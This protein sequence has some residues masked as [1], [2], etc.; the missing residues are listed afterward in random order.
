MKKS[1]IL[2]PALIAPFIGMAQESVEPKLVPNVYALHMS[3]NGK[4]IGSMAGDASIYNVETGENVY[5]NECAFGLG[6]AIANNGLGVGDSHDV[7]AV[8]L[9]GK[10]LN[11]QT[12]GGDNYW[13]CDI[14]AVTP[15][16]TRICGVIN[17]D[18][19]SQTLYIPFVASIDS[20]GN[21]GEPTMLPYPENDLFGAAPQFVTAVWISEDGKTVAGQVLDWRGQYSYPIYYV[22]GAD[23]KWSYE[24]PSAPLFNPT[25]IELPPNP[26]QD[27]PYYPE[28]EDFMS[29]TARE[30]YLAALQEFYDGLKPEAPYVDEYMDEEQYIEYA[31]AV[32]TYNQWYY[33]NLDEINAYIKIYQQVLQHTPTFSDNEIA[34]NPDGSFLA[35]KGYIQNSDSEKEGLIYLFQRGSN[36]YKTYAIP[37]DE[38]YP[39][40]LLANGMMF[41]TKGQAEVPNAFVL[42][43]GAD[44]FVS[45][46]EYFET[47]FPSVSE[48][49]DETVPFGTGVLTTNEEMT[50]FTGALVPDQLANYNEATANFYYSSYFIVLPYAGVESIV[51]DPEDGI[52][53]AYDLKGVKVIETR[54]VEEINALPAGI[55]IVNGK[56][57]LLAK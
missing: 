29:P 39:N 28:P 32:S 9:N 40:Q 14:N 16:A 5:Y 26:W 55:Y 47:D 49:L 52:Y 46:Q 51:S 17:N 4:W 36:N 3:P 38:Y 35:A 18:E 41:I 8:F 44:E 27:E 25:G 48:W 20:E 34:L 50:F 33:G 13:F 30:A 21:V 2:L 1:I 19:K 24:L 37:S 56:K 11:P 15:D 6:N 10:T 53:K 57:I 42:R 45:V 54:N 43:P 12:L 22:E 31:E 7:A 23:G